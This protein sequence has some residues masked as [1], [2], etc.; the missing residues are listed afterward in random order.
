M[1]VTVSARRFTQVRKSGKNRHF[2]RDAEIRAP[3]IMDGNK[4]VVQML[5]SGNMPSRSF[6]FAIAGTSVVATSL[7]SLDAGFRH[8]C[9]NDGHPTLVY[10]DG[11]SPWE[12][13]LRRSASHTAGAWVENMVWIF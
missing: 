1:A 11:R 10:N 7:P 6:M 5:E 2:G 8:P 12:R 9:Q 3:D 4:V 13:L